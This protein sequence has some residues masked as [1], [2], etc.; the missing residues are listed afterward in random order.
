MMKKILFLLLLPLAAAVADDNEIG[1]AV[2]DSQSADSS[3][4]AAE[5]APSAAAA[6]VICGAVDTAEYATWRAAGETPTLFPAKRV[7]FRPPSG[8]IV[9]LELTDPAEAD[10]LTLRA[11]SLRLNG[12]TVYLGYTPRRKHIESYP[13]ADVLAA[14]EK[15]AAHC[16][17]FAPAYRRSG[18]H[19][20][21][22]NRNAA[23]RMCAAARQGN[24]EIQFLGELYFGELYS[25]DVKYG[26]STFTFPGCVAMLAVN[27][28]QSGDRKAYRERL[29]KAGADGLPLIDVYTASPHPRIRHHIRVDISSDN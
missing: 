28:P 10:A 24:P 2:A 7:A 26:V 29:K 1:S 8:T 3:A 16:D 21:R 9:M 27:V 4:A 15:I 19:Y 6:P 22:I 13:V 17:G 12:L 5:I 18:A 23:A 14:I 25:G 11:A 20:D